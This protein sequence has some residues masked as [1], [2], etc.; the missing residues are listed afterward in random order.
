MRA[1]FPDDVNK[2]RIMTRSAWSK[3]TRG[4][5]GAD[6]GKQDRPAHDCIA[7]RASRAKGTRETLGAGPQG[8]ASVFILVEESSL[9][10]GSSRRGATRASLEGACALAEAP[11]A[12]T[13]GRH[14]VKVKVL[15]GRRGSDWQVRQ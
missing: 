12:T 11:K 2:A 14:R 3:N 4:S 13:T 6:T 7:A 1:G 15:L 5:K 9:M 10:A 8:W